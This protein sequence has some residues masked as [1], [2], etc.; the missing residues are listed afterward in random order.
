MEDVRGGQEEAGKGR[1]G[2]DT[3]HDKVFTEEDMAGPEFHLL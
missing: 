3:N 2:D 1:S